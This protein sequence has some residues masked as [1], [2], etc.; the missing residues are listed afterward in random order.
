MDAS[1][2]SSSVPQPLL[3]PPPSAMQA[4]TQIRTFTVHGG[5]EIDVVYT[6]EE[7]TMSKY[8][9]MYAQWY[10]EEEENKFVGLDLEYTREDPNHEE[11]NYLAVVQLSMRNHVLV[12]HYS[13]T[14]GE[15][16]ALRSFLQN[17]E[18]VFCSVD[19]RADFIKLYYEKIII[20]RENWIDIQEFVNVKGL[21][22]RGKLM[23]DGMASLATSIID[24]SYS[25]MKD[26]F[27]PER[28]NYWEERPLSDLNL[29]YAAKDAYVSYQLYVKI[30]FFLRYLVFCP[31]CKKEDTLRGHLCDKCNKAEIEVERAQKNAAAEIARLN[32]ELASVQAELARLKAPASSDNTQQTSP[33]HGKRRKMN[34]EQ[35]LESSDA[36]KSSDYWQNLRKSWTGDEQK[37]DD[38]WTTEMSDQQS[39]KSD[40]PWLT[41]PGNY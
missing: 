16:P 30:W 22:E 36:P 3:P 1:S 8:L 29:E 20:P 26:K 14:N 13:W 6:N 39:P 2:S 4:F 7:E 35:W 32:A 15:C 28:H 24:E 40:N 21:N 25:Q 23:R 19:K 18:I 9:K 5:K 17:Q 27:P 11:D 12:C 38:P 41:K 37:S 34:D 31:G 33:P 10:A